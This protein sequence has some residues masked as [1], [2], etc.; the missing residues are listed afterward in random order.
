M[1]NTDP[2]LLE[3]FNEKIQTKGN[4]NNPN[5]LVY[6]TRNKT[7]NTTQRYWE[8][9]LVTSTVGTRSSVA[10]RRPYGEFMTDMDICSTRLK[11]EMQ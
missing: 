5:P 10:V 7:A 4:D 3:K 8:K 2:S 11:M 1:Y 9:K 6:I